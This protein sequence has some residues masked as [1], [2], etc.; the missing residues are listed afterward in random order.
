MPAI[1]VSANDMLLSSDYPLDKIIYMRSGSFSVPAG[2]GL[3]ASDAIE[4]ILPF[5]PLIIGTWSTDSDFTTSKEC[6]VSG[7]EGVDPNLPYVSVKSDGTNV[8][9]TAFNPG[10]SAITAYWRAYG[11]IPSDADLDAEATAA[12]A[13]QFQ[14]NT[15]Y[16]YTKLFKAGIALAAATTT[17]DH[18]FGYRPQVIAWLK[19][20]SSFE[21]INVSG[22]IKVTTTQVIITAPSNDVHYRIYAD[23]QL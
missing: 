23:G 11:F 1:A 19:T 2:G 3:G 10:G 9:I 7:W 5:T 13:D 8:T 12:L 4:H 21:Q 17:I 18:D 6:F 22:Y 16:N 15:D 20:G 14:F